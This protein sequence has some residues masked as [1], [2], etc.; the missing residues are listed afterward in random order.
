[1]REQSTLTTDLGDNNSLYFA[2][3]PVGSAYRRS[4]SFGQ[5]LVLPGARSLEFKGR[6]VEISSRAFDLLIV[7]L[8]SRGSIVTKEELMRY[9]WPSTTVDDTNLRVQMACLRKAL[10][11]DRNLIKTVP[12][13]G[14]VAVGDKEVLDDWLNMPPLPAKSADIIPPA[15]G[16]TSILIIDR[17]PENREALHRLLMPFRATVQSFV[18]IEAFLSS[19][20][21]T[22]Q[23]TVQQ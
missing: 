5:F 1:M 11:D 15:D 23:I 20:S 6:P 16:K 4:I 14:Y 12:G 19:D 9:V 10:G 8:R 7:L 17:N 13:R 2:S 3:G 21:A 18:S 22:A